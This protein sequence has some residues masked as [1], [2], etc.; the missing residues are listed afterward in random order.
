MLSLVLLK[1]EENFGMTDED[2]QTIIQVL[3][4][5]MGPDNLLISRPKLDQLCY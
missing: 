4:R 5:I 2:F 1:Y 3:R